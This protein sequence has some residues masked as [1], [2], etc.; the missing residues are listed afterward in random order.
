M[1][2][3]QNGQQ[4][5]SSLLESHQLHQTLSIHWHRKK[6]SILSHRVHQQKNSI[7]LYVR[8]QKVVSAMQYYHQKRNHP[9]EPETGQCLSGCCTQCKK[10]QPSSW[11]TRSL[12]ARIQESSVALLYNSALDIFQ[13]QEYVGPAADTWGLGVILYTMVTGSCYLLERP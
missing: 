7:A 8:I 1:K 13:G 3:I 6:K 11:T 2:A 10:S 4:N 12:L 9:Q 5:S